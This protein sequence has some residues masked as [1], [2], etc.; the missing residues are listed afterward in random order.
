HTAS[1]PSAAKTPKCTTV[2][3][4]IRR[5]DAATPGW[6]VRAPAKAAGVWNGLP[7]ATS[8]KRK[9]RAT[10]K[11][12]MIP[13]TAPCI[14]DAFRCRF[15]WCPP[16][17]LRATRSRKA[18]AFQVRYMWCFRAEQ[19]IQGPPADITRYARRNARVL[20]RLDAKVLFCGQRLAKCA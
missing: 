15:M 13:P 7:K 14:S 17:R 6:S 10:T 18:E 9:H 20:Q 3:A 2:Y 8:I 5:G 19:Q 4:P 12:A 11:P 16:V 1:M